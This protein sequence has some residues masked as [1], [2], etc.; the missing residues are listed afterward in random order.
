MNCRH[1]SYAAGLYVLIVFFVPGC[2][3][4][5]PAPVRGYL[6]AGEKELPGFGAYGYLLFNAKPS[7]GDAPRYQHVCEA[8]QRDLS[9]AWGNTPKERTSQM[10]TFWPLNVPRSTAAKQLDCQSIVKNYDYRRA[11]G[12][13]SVIRKQSARGP[14]LAAWPKPFPEANS[15]P[16]LVLDLSDFA[17][18]DLDR[19]FGIWRDRIVGDPAVWR[20]GFNLVL[21]REAFR[22]FFQKYGDTILAIVQPAK[23]KS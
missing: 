8:F 5:G 19:A 18:E 7:G 20:K 16:V 1:L 11:S 6:Y 4:G 15:S 21:C 17:D 12:I 3:S 14:I 23:S 10:A 9:E 22:N 13:V 2:E